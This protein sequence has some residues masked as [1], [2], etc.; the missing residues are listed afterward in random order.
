LKEL[1]FDIR[2]NLKPYEKVNLTIGDFEA[3]FLLNFKESKTRATVFETFKKYIDDLGNEV[4]KEFTLW[5]NGSFVTNKINPNDIYIVILILL[6]YRVYEEN[7]NLIERKFRKYGSENIYKE[8]DAY[9]VR[10]YPRDHERF[11]A[12]D[13]DL[14]YWI[15]WFSKTK[16]N[17]R[18]Q[19]F[20]KG[21]VELKF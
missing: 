10:S 1:K 11:W 7:E 15:N 2:G 9:F 18:K 6:Y 5:I 13:Y 20:D 19:R 4:S 21:Y 3:F 12:T 14:I 17:R 16:K 8:V